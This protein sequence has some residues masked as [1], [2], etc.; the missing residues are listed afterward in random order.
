MNRQPTMIFL[1]IFGCFVFL[2]LPLLFSPESLSIRSYLTNPPT[3]KDL[4]AYL[5]VLAAF[6]INFYALIPRFYFQGKYG[7]L[8]LLNIALF[9]GVFFL[10]S[11]LIRHPAAFPLPDLPDFPPTPGGNAPFHNGPVP[12]HPQRP[13]FLMDLTQHLFLFLLVVFFAL[14]LKIRARWQQAE[15]EKKAA[16]LSV[17]KARINPHFLFNT[18][19]SIYALALEK[20]DEAPGAIVRLSEMM[21][22]VL[23]EATKEWVPLEKEIAYLE[24]YIGLQRTRFD[25]AVQPAFSVAGRP[26]GKKIAPLILIPFIENAFKHGVNAEENSEIRIE[27]VI[28]ERELQLQVFNNKVT[29]KQ[30][31]PIPSGMGIENT[32]RRL[33]ILY[34]GFHTLR[35]VDAPADFSVTLTLKGI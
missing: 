14:M 6:Y 5:V 10:P 12:F 13:S 7:F 31:D 26:E 15:E 17:L 28:G 19:N 22:Y 9:A 27:I 16:E 20:S 29:V 35:I 24:N 2:S 4:V 18:L 11:L 3:Q 23:H 32:R 1:H 34:P 21:R 33:N 25:G 8:L 30:P